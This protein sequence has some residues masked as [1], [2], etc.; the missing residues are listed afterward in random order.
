[1][2]CEGRHLARPRCA[3]PAAVAVT[4]PLRPVRAAPGQTWRA[5]SAG[6]GGVRPL[7]GSGFGREE[8]AGAGGSFAREQASPALVPV[9]C[10]GSGHPALQALPGV[11]R[12]IW[13]P[14][15]HTG[16]DNHCSSGLSAL[17]E[18]VCLAECGGNSFEASDTCKSSKIYK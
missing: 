13:R 3:G 6:A 17:S 18:G 16:V 9:S 8:S 1:M 14:L 5:A 7:E 12:G 2:Q 11:W 4:V 15:R 10:L